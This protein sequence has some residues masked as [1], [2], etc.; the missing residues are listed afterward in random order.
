MLV[1]N[2]KALFTVR[3][4]LIKLSLVL[5]LI[6]C[7]KEM[8]PTY[9]ASGKVMDDFGNGM[10]GIEVSTATGKSALTDAQGNWALTELQGRHTL[11]PADPGYLF[12]P[13]S[14][15]VKESAGNINFTASH[16]TN[17]NETRILNWFNQQ[18]LPN[19]LLESAENG[20][21]VSLYDNALAALVFML[22]GNLERAE[23]IFDFFDARIHTELLSGKGGF[24]QFRDRNGNPNNHRWMGDNAWLLIALNN[25][26]ARTGSSKYHQLASGISNWL[27]TLQDTDGGLF[28]GYGADNAILNYK[29]TEGNID[30]FNA[31]KGYNTFHSRLLTFL[32]NDRW[33][34]ADRNLVSWPGNPAYR[35]ALDNHSWSYCI[36]NNYP[37]S[38]LYSAQRFI[39]TQ[40][41]TLTNARITGYDID[42]DRDAVF[43]EGTGQ[44][45]LAFK[46]AGMQQESDHYLLE[47]EKIL[48][49]SPRHTNA[50]GFPYSSNA[51]TGYGNDPLWPEASTQIALSGGAWYLFAS[52]GFNPFAVERHKS[53]P[54]ADMFWQD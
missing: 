24:S 30:A 48:V 27:M 26:H 2:Y 17:E 52:S 50:Y 9:T 45:A 33:D 20:N 6:S 13:S 38:T 51:G 46:L 18:Q 21:V 7:Q 29:V 43:M 11:S 49:P 8:A 34:E 4:I 44:M 1:P 16:V 3:S 36:F 14:A 42:E 19:G 54:Q 53:I 5:L 35:Y 47:M 37:V 10:E 22:N 41:A 28:A 32:E 25:Y 39:T 40:T 31:V 15:E 12:T 23:R